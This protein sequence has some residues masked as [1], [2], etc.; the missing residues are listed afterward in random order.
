MAKAS[1]GGTGRGESGHRHDHGRRRLGTG[2]KEVRGKTRSSLPSPARP[3]HAGFPVSSEPEA[4]VVLGSTIT[5]SGSEVFQGELPQDKLSMSILGLWQDYRAQRAAPLFAGL[6]SVQNLEPHKP[7][8]SDV[9]LD[10]V[11]EVADPSGQDRLLQHIADQASCDAVG[12]SF[13]SA[14]IGIHEISR[15]VQEQALHRV[16]IK[17]P[18]LPQLDQAVP[19]CGL[20][21]LPTVKPQVRETGKD[22]VIGVIDTGFDLSHP[23]FRDAKGRLRV[24]GLWDQVTGTYYTKEQLLDR[25]RSGRFP[26]QDMQGHGTHV[27]SIAG[28]SRYQNVQGVAPHAEFVLVKTNML[29]L[30]RGVKW[31]FQQAGTS[32]CVVNVS[33]S[34]HWGA[35]DGTDVSERELEKLVAPGKLVV[36]AAGNDRESQ[37]HVGGKFFPGQSEFIAFDVVQQQSGDIKFLLSGWYEQSDE[38]DLLISTPTG[39]QYRVPARNAAMLKVSDPGSEFLLSCKDYRFHNLVQVEIKVTLGYERVTSLM[40]RG[41][42]LQVLCRKA[43]TGRFDMWFHNRGFGHF[44]P[45]KLVEES[46]TVG[47]PAT[48]ASVLSVGSCISKKQWDSDTGKIDDY[49]AIPGNISRFSNQGPTRDGRQKPDLCAPGQYVT[50]A[51]SSTSSSRLRSDRALQIQRLLTLEGTSMACPIVTGS[52]ALMLQKKPNLTMT[53]IQAILPQ[54]CRPISPQ[55]SSTWHPSSGYGMVDIAAALALLP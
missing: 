18:L 27:A 13:L 38:F 17:K 32:P 10:V 14:R 1:D 35:H 8:S 26:G 36:T 15:L 41:W 21:I 23:M 5:P 42:Q 44:Q 43:V 30:D 24:K 12:E 54:C 4:P 6:F 45:H 55:L 50:A 29:D 19:M 9:R 25:M 7:V 34:H 16:H 37:L 51:L 53:D 47:M 31:M 28:G 2:R 20:P 3:V 46:G 49:R 40:L 33:L 48:S 22:V 11:L 39:Q 52:V